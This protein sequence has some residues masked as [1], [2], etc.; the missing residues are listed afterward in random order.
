MSKPDHVA[1]REK[2][3]IVGSDSSLRDEIANELE[4]REYVVTAVENSDEAVA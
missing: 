1:M 3:P 2:L 4:S